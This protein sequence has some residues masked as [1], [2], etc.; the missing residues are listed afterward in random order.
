MCKRCVHRLTHPIKKSALD[1]KVESHTIPVSD[2][3]VDVGAFLEANSE[4]IIDI[5]ENAIRANA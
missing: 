4:T 1:G 5:L 3:D 2:L